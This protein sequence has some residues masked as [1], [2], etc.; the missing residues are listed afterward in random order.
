MSGICKAFM[1]AVMGLTLF[2]GGEAIAASQGALSD[3]ATKADLSR[4]RQIVAANC[5]AC[6]SFGKNSPDKMGPDLAGVFNRPRAGH[7]GY[8]GYSDAL[9]SKGGMWT[10]EDMAAWIAAPD[11]FAPGTAM[12]FDGIKKPA[13]QAAVIKFLRSLSK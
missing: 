12:V 13:D 11:A 9:K 6:H 2:A 8:V 1:S 10:D 5:A 3:F 4:G 7:P